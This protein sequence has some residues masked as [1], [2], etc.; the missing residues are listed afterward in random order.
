M[1][2]YIAGSISKDTILY[3]NQRPSEY[4]DVFINNIEDF[5]GGA[6]ANVAFSL[7]KNCYIQP[8]F[9]SN[10]GSDHLGKDLLSDCK[11]NSIDIENIRV[12]EG[13]QSTRHIIIYKDSGEVETF[14]YSGA[15]EAF[16][17]DKKILDK[18][19]KD[20]Y[21]Y[22]APIKA[23]TGNE[24]INALRDYSL[25]IFF[26]PGAALFNNKETLI[27]N[28]GCFYSLFFNENEILVYSDKEDIFSAAKYFLDKGVTIVCVT[29]GRYG[30]FSFINDQCYY[31]PGYRINVKNS[32]GCG[33]FFSSGFIGS[34]ALYG[35]VKMAL[36]FGNIMGSIATTFSSIRDFQISKL[37][38]TSFKN[39]IKERNIFKEQNS[40]LFKLSVVNY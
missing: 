40:A 20:D 2:I 5:F 7:A 14:V 6:G 4:A 15:I 19:N 11:N 25:K 23:S 35:N 13:H 38:I 9:L 16:S 33:D 1:R 18:L 10:V 26:N 8:I 29:V 39:E 22:I 27:E 31:S 12:I 36:S 28:L 24:I 21:F 17:L 37:K 30:A 3:I 34:L 32:I